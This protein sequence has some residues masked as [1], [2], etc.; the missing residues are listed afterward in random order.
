MS[1]E[2]LD[3]SIGYTIQNCVLVAIEFNT[4]DWSRNN[5]VTK[6]FGTAQWSREKVEHIWGKDGSAKKAHPGRSKL[7]ASN[8]VSGSFKALES[9]PASNSVQS[10]I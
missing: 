3:N 8:R 2:R 7:K 10:S 9:L 1:I 6:V 4:G 5:A